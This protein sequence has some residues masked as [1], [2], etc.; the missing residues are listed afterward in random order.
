MNR[1][2]FN[3]LLLLSLATGGVGTF[4]SCTDHEQD[5]QNKVLTDQKS[6]ADQIAAIR[7]FL[8]EPFENSSL[9]QR[10]KDVTEARI[11]ACEDRLDQIE[12]DYV[13]EEDLQKAIDALRDEVNDIFKN[14]YDKAYIDEKIG[15]NGQR[16]VDLEEK[17]KL[18]QMAIDNLE[19]DL[20][21]FVGDVQ[22]LFDRYSLIRSNQ[23]TSLIV[24]RTYNPVF[25]T[26]NLPIGIESNM[27]IN[28]YAKPVEEVSFPS[29]VGQNEGTNNDLFKP[30]F[31]LPI[32]AADVFTLGTGEVKIEKFGDLY[33]TINPLERNFNGQKFTLVKSNG[34]ALPAEFTA[35]ESDDILY[36]GY[37][38]GDN[39]LYK[40]SIA[41]E[42]GEDEAL[43]NATEFKIES[44][45]KTAF[46]NVIKNH[47]KEDVAL[48]AK[49]IYSQFDGKVPAY[50]A[51]VS[52]NENVEGAVPDTVKDMQGTEVTKSVI[53]G[54]DLAVATFYPLSYTTNALND[55][56]QGIN[57][58]LPV[59]GSLKERFE[60]VFNYVH[61][62]LNFGF[63]NIKIDDI[64]IDLSS[65]KVNVDMDKVTISLEGCPV[66][67][68]DK[69]GNPLMG[70]ENIVG[71]LGP[72]ANV[73]LDYN[74]TDVDNPNK[75]ALN[76]LVDSIKDAIEDM[77]NGKGDN[78][79]TTQINS[80][81][82][83]QIG[84]I[85]GQV[86]DQ[87]ASV[88]NK[89]Y[90]SLA[91]IQ[92]RV[93]AELNGTLGSAAQSLVNLYDAFAKRVNEF[94]D[95][96]SYYLQS[97]MAYEAVDGGIH[98]LSTVKN[99]PTYVDK[100]ALRFFMTSYNAE[101]IVP[102]FKK[103]VAI[104][105]VGDTNADAALNSKAGSD[106]NKVLTGRQQSLAFNS[107]AL[108][109]GKTYEIFYQTLDFRGHTSTHV[110]YIHVR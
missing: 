104:T 17:A 79:L 85:V 81:L 28:Y 38:R 57:K 103:Y 48:L 80:Q 14:Y 49:A 68:A 25:G 24:E 108:E 65:V 86:N 87:L 77:L 21:H 63:D 9:D 62:H 88:Q 46:K 105:K 11:K 100:G 42:N 35:E 8:G 110:Y 102:A 101:L 106:L 18:Q 96:P 26:L 98:H 31:T 5:F 67:K 2:F 109:S 74:G 39:G 15:E 7:A 32:A 13:T 60:H 22:D 45:L 1:K 55:I 70:D 84:N 6:F 72:E 78:S 76:P 56:E 97:V 107:A 52:W 43:V 92:S 29:G 47:G 99:D 30:G 34:E 19:G 69:D 54:Y 44:E 53:S 59:I 90:D 82:Q 33:M 27:L 93:N 51:K 94:L 50:A 64:S 36:F 89:V 41:P 91:S 23:I 40:A 4:T 20:A 71:V 10:I 16:I 75:D 12:A 61:D 83:E 66:Y 3:G 95:D 37:T 58:R 73:T